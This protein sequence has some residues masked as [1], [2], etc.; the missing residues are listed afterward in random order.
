METTQRQSYLDW[1]RI[2]SIVGVLFF[3]SA[4]PFVAEDDW[5]IKN[6]QTSNLLM[7]SNHFL[8][9]FRMPL[10]F[11]ISGTVSYYMMQRRSTLSF[12]G[13]RFRRLFIP[14]LVGMFIIVPPQI[15]MERL[16]HG[17]KGGFWDWYPSVFNFVP[18]PKGGSFS[19]HHL[20]FIAYLFI[21]DLIFAPMFAWLISPKSDGFKQK[22]AALAQGKWVYLLMLP[23]IIWFTF[24]SWQLPETNDLIHDGCYF[25]YWLFFVLVGFICITQ[26]KLMD[27]LERNR[28]FALTIGFLSLMMWE[29]MRWNKIEPQHENWPFHHILFSYAFTALRPVIAWGWVLALVGYGKHYFNR[30]HKVLNYLNQAVYPFYILHQTVIVLVV[31]YI[32]QTPNESI[33]SKYIYTVGI[34][35]F[36]TV[37]T[38]HL[39]IRPYALTRF[40]FGMKPK[41]KPKPVIE[42]PTEEIRAVVTLST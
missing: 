13:L 38:Y 5:H 26:P 28:R 41:D 19:W 11:F 30:S 40:L 33:L 10:L 32:V 25:V 17:Y 31:Y 18:Y 6:A 8:H 21:Y 3:H 42:A 1:L 7:E 36:V 20:W 16:V 34:T 15:F 22:L 23:G 27:S 2:L 37:L 12:I 35:F 9:L 24:T 29:V 39:L 4:M 14:L